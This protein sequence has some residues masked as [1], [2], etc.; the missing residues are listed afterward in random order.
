[1][2]NSKNN[3]YITEKILHGFAANVIPV[4]WGAENIHDYFNKDR[5]INVKS[6]NIDDINDAIDMIIMILNDDNKFIDMINKPI[7]ANN[8]IPLTINNISL[9]VKHL[10]NIEKKQR[11]KFITFG[12]PKFNYQNRVK[13]ICYEATNLDFFDEIVGFTDI[14]LKN[15]TTFWAKHGEF[16][17]NN[18]RGYGYWLWKPFLIKK[19]LEGI[20]DNDILLL[21]KHSSS[22]KS[23]YISYCDHTTYSGR[24]KVRRL[25]PNL[26]F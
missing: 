23:F 20:N 10:L 15:D 3:N 6:F 24:E 7:Y 19:A 1:M 8:Y 18:K 9:D 17:E 16:I 26:V 2:E 25:I 12:G 5:F 21:V 13:R 4:Y 14:D 22:L 11:K